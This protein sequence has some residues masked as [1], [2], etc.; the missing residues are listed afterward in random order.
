MTTSALQDLLAREQPPR[1]LHVL[2]GEVFDAARIPGSLNACIYETAFGENVAA[3]LPDK[4]VPVVVYGSGPGSREAEVAADALRD[5]GYRDVAVFEGGLAGW[6]AAGLVCEGTGALPSAQRPAD[7][8]YL[9][10]TADSLVR[11]TGRNLFN[12]HSGTVGLAGGELEVRDGLLLSAAFSVA[13]DTIACEDIADSS[14]NRMLI[15]HLE[16]ADFFDVA[17]F[18]VATFAMTACTA[19]PEAPEGRENFRL[20]GAL[21]VRGITRPVEFPAVVAVDGGGRLTG[22]ACLDVDRTEF[23]SIYGSGRFFRFLGRH[24][25]NDV[26]HLHLKIHAARRTP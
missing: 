20:Q 6:R 3:L 10:E 19:L 8:V 22:Q 25:V 21:T 7:G 16:S 5:A 12:H 11:W 1:L 2:P 17:S 23:G 13:M 18:P 24:V 15:A 26:L 9:V 14:I 4:S